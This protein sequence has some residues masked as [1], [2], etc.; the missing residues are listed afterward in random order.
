M[1]GGD[2]L[3]RRSTAIHQANF[4]CHIQQQL[5]NIPELSTMP[6]R[7]EFNEKITKTNCPPS[8]RQARQSRTRCSSAFAPG[9]PIRIRQ[10]RIQGS[11]PQENRHGCR[12]GPCF[13]DPSFRLQGGSLESR[14]RTTSS[15]LD[16]F[17][18][19]TQRVAEPDRSSHPDAHR[20]C[21]STTD[22]SNF[23][24]S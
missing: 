11:N 16:A 14:H 7:T 22:S 10:P 24:G 21:L 19:R 5:N 13:S 8:T 4:P 3:P 1:S 15:L 20:D 18:H 2:K 23:R 6:E 9:R 12:S 17:Y